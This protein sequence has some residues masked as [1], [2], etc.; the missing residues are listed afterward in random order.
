ME[1]LYLATVSILI[2]IS[3]D[4]IRIRTVKHGYLYCLMVLILMFWVQQPNLSVL[5][6]S[7]SILII[8]FVLHLLRFLGAGDTKL[9]F[10][11]SLGVSPNNLS[12]LFFGIAFFSVILIFVYLIVAAIK[13]MAYVKQRGLPFA[14]PISCA[15]AL[16]MFLSNCCS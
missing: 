5:P 13:G 16:T 3:I 8:G 12:L 9:L 6:Y 7:I 10:V 4:D 11:I 1:V 15:G 2:L 14:V